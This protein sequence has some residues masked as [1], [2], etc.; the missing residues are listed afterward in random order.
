MYYFYEQ[1]RGNPELAA[2]RTYRQRT[3]E[4][5]DH[6][7]ATTMVD[8]PATDWTA[9][10]KAAARKA[11]A[12]DVGICAYRAEWSFVDCPAPQGKWAIVM[13]FEHAYEKMDAAPADAAYLE[14]MRQY[15]RAGGHLERPGQL[16]QGPG[17]FS[18]SQDRPHDR[19]RPDD[20]R[21]D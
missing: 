6:D 11:G 13:A 14:V 2:A 17:P 8:K 9:L 3:A 18:R 12:D 4:I 21:R 10:I 5:P 19:G 20:P 15:A 1:S 16:D 7:V